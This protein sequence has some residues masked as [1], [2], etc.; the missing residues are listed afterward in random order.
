MVFYPRWSRE[1]SVN[2]MDS[3]SFL[4]LAGLDLDNVYYEIE[5]LCI[6]GKR[7]E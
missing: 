5:T 7:S 4:F 3:T 1:V 2:V 6:F